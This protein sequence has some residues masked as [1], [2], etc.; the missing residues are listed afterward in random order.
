MAARPLAVGVTI[1]PAD[2]KVDKVVPATF[3]KGAFSK[4]EEVVDRS[5]ISNILVDEPVLD[6]RLA[7]RGSGV[8]LAPIIPVGMRA[9]SIRVN[10][11]AGSPALCCPGMRVDVLVTGRPAQPE[12]HG[13]H[14]L[15]AEHAGS[16]GRARRCSPTPGPGD[17]RSDRDLAGHDPAQAEILT[18][19]NGEGRIQL[20]LRNGSDQRNHED[21]GQELSELYGGPRQQSPERGAPRPRRRGSWCCRA[22]HRPAASSSAR[23]DCGDPGHPDGA[24]K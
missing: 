16:L 24:W 21:A 3:P 20:V 18:L 10:D 6:A 12:R 23:P 19:A 22:A 7:P 9:V 2:L 15:P 14:H 4:M 1:K 11:V 17:S 5:V 13:Y 8:G